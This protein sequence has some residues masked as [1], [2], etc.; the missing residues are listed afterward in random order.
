MFDLI[1]TD[2]I[3]DVLK[4]AGGTILGIVVSFLFWKYQEWRRYG[5]WKVVVKN[6][7]ATLCVRPV[8]SRK[9]KEVM[10][11][12]STLSV[13]LK[14]VVSPFGWLSLDLVSEEAKDR[15]LFYISVKGRAWVIDLS[16]NPPKKGPGGQG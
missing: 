2:T 7:Q 5:G 13:F 1:S 12:L 9:V 11:D 8:G 15:G 16:K 6:D 10:D 4:S 14:G 3:L